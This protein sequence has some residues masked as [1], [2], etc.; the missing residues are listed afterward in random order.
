M[1]AT[2][3]FEAFGLNWLIVVCSGVFCVWGFESEGFIYSDSERVECGLL[4]CSECTSWA[5][6]A[7]SV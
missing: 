7:Q 4:V 5:G 6:I 3:S 2:G 1:W